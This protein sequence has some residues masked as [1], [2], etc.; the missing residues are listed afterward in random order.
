[1]VLTTYHRTNIHPHR[2]AY[3]KHSSS[4]LLPPRKRGNRLKFIQHKSIASS[5]LLPK[6]RPDIM[7]TNYYC[8][9]TNNSPSGFSVVTL[10][11]PFPHIYNTRTSEMEAWQRGICMQKTA[12]KYDLTYSIILGLPQDPCKQMLRVRS[13][14]SHLH[15][16]HKQT[17]PLCELISK[18]LSY[19]MDPPSSNDIHFCSSIHTTSYTFIRSPLVLNETSRGPHRKSINYSFYSNCSNNSGSLHYPQNDCK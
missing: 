8:C 9:A 11:L 14:C 3:H 16:P 1:M 18:L 13:F 17:P 7:K 6:F 15:W 10:Y 19:N 12:Y 2:C 5:S 4:R